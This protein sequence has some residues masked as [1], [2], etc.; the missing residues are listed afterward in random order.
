[1]D[2]RSLECFVALAEELHFHRAAR[3]CHISQP[4]LSQ[5]LRRL[6][7]QLQAQL[8]LRNNRQVS[9]TR[10]GS[11][12]LAEARKLLNAMN[13]AVDLARATDQGIIGHLSVGATASALFI[14]LPDIVMRFKA[15]L[16]HVRLQLHHM[17]TE[18]QEAALRNEDIQVGICHPP[19]S[20][21]S[22]ECDLLAE[23]RFGL[24][25]SEQNPLAQKQRLSLKDLSEQT[26]ILF[27]RDV[28]PRLHDHIIS[29]CH[30]EGFSP[31]Q[32]VEAAPAQ[33]IV[34]MA[35]CNVGV[36]FIASRVQH[37]HRPPAIFRQLS[38]PA[39]YFTLGAAYASHRVT[40]ML[41][42][43]LDIAQEVGAAA[44]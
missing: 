19:L 27:P 32:I 44:D 41:K 18:E 26:F 5:Q 22:L 31:R 12:F 17:T 15:A 6:E 4:G 10:A 28:G 11:V 9:L 23:L 42:Q 29:L 14:L 21:S 13:N 37:H 1:M 20:D 16:P 43:F 3:R 25:L 24:V 2:K 36:G 33:S 34:A 40:P 35:A 38:G 39:P 30:Q 7:E 8:V